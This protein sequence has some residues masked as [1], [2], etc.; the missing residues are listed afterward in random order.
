MPF[1]NAYS[2]TEKLLLNDITSQ[3]QMMSPEN[4]RLSPD[5]PQGLTP[6]N[7]LEP[8]FGSPKEVKNGLIFPK[9]KSTQKKSMIVI[10]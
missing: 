9:M 8:I 3:S 6:R 10:L 5:S 4:Q 1:R 2:T 7:L